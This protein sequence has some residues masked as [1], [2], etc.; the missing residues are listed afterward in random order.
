MEL[1]L[2]DDLKLMV[3][4][5]RTDVEWFCGYS[6]NMAIFTLTVYLAVKCWIPCVL[7]QAVP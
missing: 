4:L 7:V 3:K 5:I 1:I 6:S 2:N